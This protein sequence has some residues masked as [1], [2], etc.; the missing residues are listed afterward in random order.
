[1]ASRSRARSL[2]WADS[3]ANRERI[4]AAPWRIPIRRVR[5]IM[6]PAGEEGIDFLLRNRRVFAPD[7]PS[8]KLF[9]RL[10]QVERKPQSRTQF[11]GV[12]HHVLLY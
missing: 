6:N 7:S 2:A 3:F 9:G 11:L 4:S 1:M 12:R 10:E 5:P 8:E